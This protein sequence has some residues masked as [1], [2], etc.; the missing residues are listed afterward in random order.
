MA[1]LA[2]VSRNV[3]KMADQNAPEADIDGYL[4][5][6]GVTP[7]RIRAFNKGVKNYSLTDKV[8][9]NFTMGIGDKAAALGTAIGGELAEV[10]RGGEKRP[11]TE[12]YSDSLAATD[13]GEAKFNEERPVARVLAAPLNI[14]GAGPRAAAAGM[15]TLRQAAQQGAT[16]GAGAG[17]GGARGD[18]QDQI[19]Q[20]AIGAGGGAILGP[21]AQA[22]ANRL[23]SGLA[24]RAAARNADPR[25]VERA[26]VAAA[27]GRQDIRVLPADTGGVMAKMASSAA[28]Q[29]PIAAPLLRRG[30]DRA[31]A[32]AE[33]AI[34]RTAAP[35]GRALDDGQIG[36]AAQAGA[37]TFIH[38]TRDIGGRLYERAE[39]LAGSAQVTPINAL[40]AVDR[41]IAELSLTP[42]T[43]AQAL[44][45]LNGLR[46]D[47]AR[48]ALPLQA[49]RDI[50]TSIRTRMIGDG[51]RGTDVERR[52][53]QVATAAADDIT[54]ALSGN[55]SAL[56]AYSRADRFYRGRVETIDDTLSKIL[57]RTDNL[58]A[59]QA[60][61]RL[62]QMSTT[63][64]DSANL[65]GILRALPRDTRG[66]VSA[67]ILTRLGRATA[68]GQNSTGTAFSPATFGTS[69]NNMTPRARAALFPD[70]THRAAVNDIATVVIDGMKQSGKFANSSNTG[71]A[72]IGGATG[73]AFLVE[74]V[75]ATLSVVGQGAAG[76][77]LASPAF[78][79]WLAP[80]LRATNLPALRARLEVL[81]RLAAANPAVGAEIG[82]FMRAAND[83]L[84]RLAAERGGGENEQPQLQ[85]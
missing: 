32:D 45:V 28:N 39:R 76:A 38:R 62:I 85:Q 25:L 60:A 30:A 34:A 72:L 64:G 23:A 80:T 2:K 82:A 6:E 83:N 44:N 43:N 52:V 70:A 37:R 24:N 33:A 77:L 59:E 51:L 36:E 8:A 58:S 18:A 14:L 74:P 19:T 46:D 40:Q 15:T 17:F 12:R 54:T 26:N 9:S 84:A 21:L 56:A 1:D 49:V 65:A 4:A 63:R 61:S 67:S 13:A 66:D 79:R 78:A 55:P 27:A 57:G 53:G 29:S 81:P 68:G 5:T 20:T 42:T 73:G 11:F 69:W 48:G 35:M 75:T 47:L 31:V 22:G 16:I 71:S 50:R 7:A 3:R 10:F 41:N